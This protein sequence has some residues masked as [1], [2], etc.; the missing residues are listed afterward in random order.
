MLGGNTSDFGARFRFCRLDPLYVILAGLSELIA[1]ASWRNGD[2]ED[3]LQ[4]A[5]ASS[6]QVNAIVTRDTAGYST[7]P[8]RLQT[9]A[10]VIARLSPTAPE[11]TG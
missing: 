9:A 3:Y 10:Q 2:L 8:V 5:L 11:T 7:S 4:M 1:A 6:A